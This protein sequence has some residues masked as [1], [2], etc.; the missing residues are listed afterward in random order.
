MGRNGVNKF[1]DTRAKTE[2]SGLFFGG[3]YDYT[4]S[5]T[6][7]KKY[8]EKL[9]APVKEFYTFKQSAQSPIFEEPEKVKKIM[10][11]NVLNGATLLAYLL[12]Q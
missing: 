11:K 7:A 3:G 4:V 12:K 9:Q 1:D 2:H 5:C 10:L 8:F 6:L